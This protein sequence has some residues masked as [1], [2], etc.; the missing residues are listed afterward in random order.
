MK[1]KTVKWKCNSCG[2]VYE[3]SELGCPVCDSK[4]AQKITGEVIEIEDL[5]ISKS[6]QKYI[7]RY[8]KGRPALKREK[9]RLKKRKM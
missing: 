4:K 3:A 1:E 6:K 8:K 2:A 9:Q 5:S 7:S